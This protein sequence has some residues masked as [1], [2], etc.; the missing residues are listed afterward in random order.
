MIAQYECIH[1]E[2][3]ELSAVCLESHCR[4]RLSC[5][6]CLSSNQEH[7][8]HEKVKFTEFMKVWDVVEKSKGKTRQLFRKVFYR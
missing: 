1:H 5:E 8:L 3:K 6:Q 2:N 4:D 7:A